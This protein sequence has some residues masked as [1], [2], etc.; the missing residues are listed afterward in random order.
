MREARS[1]WRVSDAV[2]YEAMRTRLNEVVASLLAVARSRG[3][4]GASIREEVVDL[5]RTAL[6]VDGFD[7]TEVDAFTARLETHRGQGSV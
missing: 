1:T 3:D 6:T 2:A 7:R 5:R 4:D